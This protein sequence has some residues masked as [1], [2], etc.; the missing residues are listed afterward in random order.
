MFYN[1]SSYPYAYL[2]ILELSKENLSLK[3]ELQNYETQKHADKN[4]L[5]AM[6]ELVDSLTQ[7]KLN[8]TTTINELQ[9]KILKL[10]SA[11][12]LLNEEN[13]KYSQYDIENE[14][15]KRQ[16]KRLAEENDEVLKDFETLEKKFEDVSKISLEHQKGLLLLEKSSEKIEIEN[17]SLRDEV[18]L[19]N[20]NYEELK[21]ML[22]IKEQELKSHQI[23]QKELKSNENAEYK[24]L[25]TEFTELKEQKFKSDEKL[26]LFKTKLKEFSV[27]LKQMKET[28]E[29]LIEI[30]N[31]YSSTVPKWQSD[32]SN[33]SKVFIEKIGHYEKRISELENEL[34]A[35]KSIECKQ[36]NGM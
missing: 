9:N 27:S 33:I 22:E 18:K 12:K 13:C 11:L 30:V 23:I 2:F 36:E 20:K 29:S 10:E 5:K 4:C 17:K 16:I 28:R 25:Q 26:K 15:L 32:L 35:L 24:R 19:K 34:V 21:K 6:Q 3:E 1:A 31:E 14:S 7:N 8:S